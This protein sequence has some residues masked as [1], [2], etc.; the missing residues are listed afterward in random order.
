MKSVYGGRKAGGANQFLASKL[1][2]GGFGEPLVLICLTPLL[3]MFFIEL[4]PSQNKI[5]QIF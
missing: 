4:K 5:L 1:V 2:L 3:L